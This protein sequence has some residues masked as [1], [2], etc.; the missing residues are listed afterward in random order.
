VP[1]FATRHLDIEIALAQLTRRL[2]RQFE[3]VIAPELVTATV[4]SIASRWHDAP[5]QDFVPL[6]AERRSRDHLRSVV[7]ERAGASCMH[8]ADGTDCVVS[9]GSGQ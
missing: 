3:N 1:G 9:S 8:G 4:A 2:V 6:L 7:A 5:V